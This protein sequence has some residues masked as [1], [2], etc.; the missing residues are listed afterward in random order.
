MRGRRKIRLKE[1]THTLTHGNVLSV[2]AG[3]NTRLEFTQG[4]PSRSWQQATRILP[5]QVRKYVGNRHGQADG[6]TPPS[7]QRPS[8]FLLCFLQ[9]LN[10]SKSRVDSGRAALSLLVRSQ[11][12]FGAISFWAHP[13]GRS[14][15]ITKKTNKQELTGGHPPLFS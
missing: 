3:T 6:E 15:A 10:F 11:R 14:Q 12:S 2:N 13:V 4:V 5:I 9:F 7:D 1:S 8:S